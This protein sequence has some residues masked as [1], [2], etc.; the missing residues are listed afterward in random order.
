M[1][2]SVKS[3]TL[4]L[5]TAALILSATACGATSASDNSTAS[6]G[7][8]E[9][10]GP[11]CASLPTSGPGSVAE[12]EKQRVDSAVSGIPVLSTLVTQ[13]QAAGLAGTL[14]SAEGVTVF[15]PTNDAFASVSADTLKTLAADPTGALATV[16]EYHVVQGQLAPDQLVGTH[17][18]IEGQDLT[19]TGV[20][21][22]FTIN[23]TAEIVCGNIKT[24]NA[25]VYLIDGVLVPPTTSQP[26]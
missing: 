18:T 4:T 19:I 10:F 7:S 13:A 12:I 6:P 5:G 9:L 16:L 20:D 2:T 22:D 24:A 21:D 26:E 17:P 11:A 23:D 14:N 15:A 1:L 3:T 8:D 25:L